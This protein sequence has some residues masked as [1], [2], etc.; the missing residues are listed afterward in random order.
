[1]KKNLSSQLQIFLICQRR[2]GLL[3]YTILVLVLFL[4]LYWNSIGAINTKLLPNL[5]NENSTYKTVGPDWHWSISALS[6]FFD[7]KKINGWTLV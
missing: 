5:R 7:Q 4:L 1:M 2:V 3:F 6:L